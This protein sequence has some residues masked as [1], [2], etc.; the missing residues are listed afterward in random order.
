[1]QE[2]DGSTGRGRG[3]DDPRAV[4][5]LTAEHWSLL[6]SRNLGYQE[7]FGR[8]T[9]FV[10][11]LSG[12]I[13]ALA[14]LAQATR[15]SREALSIGLLF[16]LVDLF[17]GIATFGRSLAINLED[18]RWV[19]G[20][21]LL[22]QA[23]VRIVPELAQYFVTT[24]GPGR[25]EHPL[26]HGSEQSV[27]NLAT[28]LSTTSSVVATLNSVLAGAIASDLAALTGRTLMMSMFIGAAISGISGALHV[29]FA[30]RFRRRHELS[31]APAGTG[32][33]SR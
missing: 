19:D 10:G 1:L 33:G 22:R 9:I 21:R 5:I 16:M 24:H 14:F 7:M 25:G 11:I 6:A 15:F 20:M 23:Y 18:A 2:A 27:A 17:V 8:T 32:Q 29:R 4:A 30:A 28:S 26:G 12:T 3:L 13:V 31:A